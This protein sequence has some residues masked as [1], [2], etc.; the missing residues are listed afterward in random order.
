MAKKIAKWVSFDGREYNNEPAA[1]RRDKLLL[2]LF[3]L[4]MKLDAF[5]GSRDTSAKTEWYGTEADF[6]LET[7]E[8]M[9]QWMFARG[10]ITL[11]E[12]GEGDHLK[13]TVNRG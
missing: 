12:D 11:S 10:N 2:K 4:D 3:M 8:Q 9:I 6:V 7:M 5:M 1:V 13:M